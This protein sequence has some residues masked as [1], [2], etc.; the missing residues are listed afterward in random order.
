LCDQGRSS[1]GWLLNERKSFLSY[2][3][4]IGPFC[5]RALLY[6]LS[7][8]PCWPVGRGSSFVLCY[9]PFGLP[10]DWSF[11]NCGFCFGSGWLQMGDRVL[12]SVASQIVGC[13]DSLR[14]AP[15]NHTTRFCFL[16]YTRNLP[17]RLETRTKESNIC[18]SLWV[19]SPWA[20]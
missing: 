12:F 14:S 8:D 4:G 17:T 5:T 2:S 19:A 1:A 6:E 9:T 10:L 20:Q 16:T 15:S 18:A 13:F 7:F 3:F 11:L